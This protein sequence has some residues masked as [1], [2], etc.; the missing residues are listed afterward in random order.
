MLVPAWFETPHCMPRQL[1]F[2]CA[3]WCEHVCGGVA[4]RTW[5]PAGTPTL[6]HTNRCEGPDLAKSQPAAVRGRQ[7]REKLQCGEEKRHTDRG[8]HNT[9][10][11][12]GQRDAVGSQPTVATRRPPPQSRVNT[13]R[14]S[15]TRLSSS[16]DVGKCMPGSS[17]WMTPGHAGVAVAMRHHRPTDNEVQSIAANLQ[18]RH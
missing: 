14:S 15:G 8:P 4:C 11:K 12:T 5:M 6:Q 9:R 7:R 18:V 1:V 2:Q 16:W 13:R 10:V 17:H 3:P